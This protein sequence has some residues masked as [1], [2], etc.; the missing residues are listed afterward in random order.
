VSERPTVTLHLGDQSWH[1]GPGWYYT[2]DEYEDEGSCGAFPSRDAAIA[3]AKSDGY[4]TA[5]VHGETTCQRTERYRCALCLEF[6]CWCKGAADGVDEVV[7]ALGREGICDDC[8]AK[9][10]RAFR[11]GFEV[12][13]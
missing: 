5:A 11:E 6:V 7:K 4:A 13:S 2:I 1:D 12:A 8:Y 9:L 3:H 10:A